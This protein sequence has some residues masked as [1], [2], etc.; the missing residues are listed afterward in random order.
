MGKREKNPRLRGCEL[1]P[2]L[3]LLAALEPLLPWNGAGLGG[4][5]GLGIPWAAWGRGEPRCSST[6][7]PSALPALP[8]TQHLPA[9]AVSEVG[10]APRTLHGA[11]SPSP[12]SSWCCSGQEKGLSSTH[13]AAS[14]ILCSIP[15]PGSPVE[16]PWD[17]LS[18]L[19]RVGRSSPSLWSCLQTSFGPSFPRE[20]FQLSAGSETTKSILSPCV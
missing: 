13:S 6:C 15:S 9:P 8:R 1:L 12:W 2:A 19:D 20:L 5:R 10:R 7:E 14:G 18:A 11:L 16:H 3:I 17:E 4:R